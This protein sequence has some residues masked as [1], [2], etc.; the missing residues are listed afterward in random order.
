MVGTM[1]FYSVKPVSK[2][3]FIV[4]LTIFALFLVQEHYFKDLEFKKE[5]VEVEVK[6][7]GAYFEENTEYRI[8][9]IPR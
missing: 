9:R 1:N 5:Q 6:K 2:L 8:F 4:V 3:V 7:V